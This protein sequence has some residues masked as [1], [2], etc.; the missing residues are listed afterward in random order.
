MFEGSLMVASSSSSGVVVS[1]GDALLSERAF[2]LGNIA[3][4]FHMGSMVFRQHH[5]QVVHRPASSIQQITQTGLCL[6][7]MLLLQLSLAY[8][9]IEMSPINPT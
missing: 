9:R 4:V 3:Q 8:F 1:T 2:V 5:A 6:A 7:G